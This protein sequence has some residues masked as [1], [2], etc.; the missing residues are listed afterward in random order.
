M[1]SDP[2]VCSS[3][4]NLD[5]LVTLSVIRIIKSVAVYGAAEYNE[6]SLAPRKELVSISH[7]LV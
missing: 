3:S 7:G 1:L 6:S 4:L 5:F 2:D